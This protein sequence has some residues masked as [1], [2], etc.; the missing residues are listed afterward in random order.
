MRVFVQNEAGSRTKHIHDEKRLVLL[1]TTEVSRAYPYPYGFIL[2]T[3]GGDGDNL[4]CFVLTDA[5]LKS[6]TIHE[7]EPV[8]LMEQVE[9]GEQDH[10]VLAVPVGA[11]LTVPD[12]AEATLRTFVMHVF[13]H[14]EGKQMHVGAFLDADAARAHIAACRDDLGQGA[15]R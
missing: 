8:A 12:D 13:D 4:D 1:R 2:G 14:V 15:L 6:G 10:N 9:D 7:C 5:P 11:S 3:T